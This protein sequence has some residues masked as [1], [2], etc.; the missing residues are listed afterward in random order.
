MLKT[1][2]TDF[3]LFDFAQENRLFLIAWV[4]F[5]FGYKRFPWLV[6]QAEFPFLHSP[7]RV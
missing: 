6:L 3:Y 7:T 1:R 2:P 5:T 4:S